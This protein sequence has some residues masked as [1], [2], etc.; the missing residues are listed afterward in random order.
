MV[1]V[2]R[3]LGKAK[4]SSSLGSAG[5]QKVIN[6]AGTRTTPFPLRHNMYVQTVDASVTPRSLS[7]IRAGMKLSSLIA[8]TVKLST[9]SWGNTQHNRVRF[10]VKAGEYQDNLDR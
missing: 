6:S 5:V 8:F 10:I 2:R 7:N 1:L 3:I 4:N 9:F